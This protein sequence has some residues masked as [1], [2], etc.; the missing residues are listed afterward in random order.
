MRE[1]NTSK[2]FI[3]DNSS[4]MPY[5]PKEIDQDR[6]AGSF[7]TN[8]EDRVAWKVVVSARR[9][10]TWVGF[11]QNKF[12]EN[13]HGEEESIKSF[14]DAFHNM[15]ENGYLE[16]IGLKEGFWSWTNYFRIPIVC[17]TDKFIIRLWEYQNKPK[18]KKEHTL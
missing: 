3:M 8:A 6:I 10:S 11:T 5:L 18:S 2:V 14:R 7:C 9:H 1:I 13:Q 16:I 15:V 4:E 12:L 17:P